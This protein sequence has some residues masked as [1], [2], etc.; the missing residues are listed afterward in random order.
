MLPEA[1]SNG[2]CSLN[3]GEEKL[4]FSC[5]M[6]LDDKGNLKE[7]QFQKSI[8]CSRVRGVYAEV[9]HLFEGTAGEDLL[10][11]YAPV[12]DSL[13]AG[14]ELAQLLEQKSRRRGTMD[15]ET[16]ESRFCLDEKG[17]CVAVVP[18]TQGISEKMIE[19]FMIAANQAAAH[20]GKSAGIPFVYRVHEEP[21]P[22]RVETLHQL[23]AGLGMDAKSLHP[24]VSPADLARLLRQAE[25]TPARNII[26][27]QILRTMAKARYDSQPLG[28]YGL[29]L[30]DYCHFTSPIRRYPDT[31]VHRILSDLVK[32][33][34]VERLKRKYS[35]FVKEAS[36]FSSACEIRAQQAERQAEK[37]YMA[38][39]M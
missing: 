28:H 37:C 8:I 18:R 27:H 7:Y 25:K 16:S 14:R 1:L 29:N 5:L 31:A 10:E 6:I 34:S 38:E 3:A 22:E 24:G 33:V 20:Y 11:K 4:A 21:D 36:S 13:K 26:S 35:S 19:Q 15:L 2:C 39:Y 12:L 17:V 32:G 9:N 23:A 30:E